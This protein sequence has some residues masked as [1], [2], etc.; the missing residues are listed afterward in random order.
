M[1]NKNYHYNFITYSSGTNDDK[2]KKNYYKYGYRIES[3]ID[4]LFSINKVKCNLGY[5]YS[6]N[7]KC[8]LKSKI[9]VYLITKL[10]NKLLINLLNNYP[11]IDLR[12]GSLQ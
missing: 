9:K 2:E 8:M 4:W 6:E 5:Y 3:T 12:I 11:F 10:E 1:Y 7:G